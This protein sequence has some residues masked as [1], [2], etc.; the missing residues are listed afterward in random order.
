MV[1]SS[2]VSELVVGL[3]AEGQRLVI[4]LEGQVG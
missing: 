1:A 3:R 2:E 4:F